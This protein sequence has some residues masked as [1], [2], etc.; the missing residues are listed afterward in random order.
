MRAIPSGV[1]TEAGTA[2]TRAG[3]VAA[4][5]TIENFILVSLIRELSGC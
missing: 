3:T 4:R 1:S 5:V 2:A